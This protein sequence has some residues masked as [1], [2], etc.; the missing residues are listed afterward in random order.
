MVAEA[1]RV[2]LPRR[3]VLRLDE[4]PGGSAATHLRFSR[5]HVG[6]DQDLADADVLAHGPQGGL[7]RLARTQDRHAGDLGRGDEDGSLE[8]ERREP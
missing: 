2:E 6:L 5:I 8:G 7:H 3:H 4:G 1:G